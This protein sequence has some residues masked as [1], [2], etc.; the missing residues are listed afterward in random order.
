[1]E[2]SSPDTIKEQFRTTFEG[3][4]ETFIEIETVSEVSNGEQMARRVVAE[5]MQPLAA[6]RDQQGDVTASCD[7]S[8]CTLGFSTGGVHATLEIRILVLPA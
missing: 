6:M 5:Q 8:S 4:I 1:M 7:L 3:R 2:Y